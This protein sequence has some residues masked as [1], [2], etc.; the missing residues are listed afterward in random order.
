MKFGIPTDR[1]WNNKSS[2]NLNSVNTYAQVLGSALA[3]KTGLPAPYASAVQVRFNG[4]NEAPSGGGMF[5]SYAHVEV[6]DGEWARDHYPDDP[7][8]NAYSKRRPECFLEYQGTNPQNYVNCAFDKESNASEND[9][10]DVMNLTLAL[11]PDT[12]SDNEYVAAVRRNL[13]VDLWLRHF[14]VLFLMNYNETAIANG[15]DDDYDLYRG[16]IDPRFILLPHDFDSIFGSAG[17]TPDNLFLAASNPN[18]RTVSRF[19]HHPEFEPLFFA[20]YRRQLAGMF[21]TNNLFPLMDQVLGDWVPAGTITS[22][23]NNAQNRINYVLSALPPEPVVVRATIGGEPD[24]PT[25]LNTA[26]LNVGG[27]DITHY[28]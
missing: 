22:M 11:D 28:R 10:T 21:S 18:F 24:S 20:E 15:A 8:G 1:V 27:T 13:N 6:L 12:T 4:V 2:L 3:P 19:L 5:G 7:N 9:W 16:L 25:Y 14:V 23:K 26:S 17:N